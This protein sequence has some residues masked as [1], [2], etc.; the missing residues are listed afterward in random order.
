MFNEMTAE[1]VIK[2]FE[3]AYYVRMTVHDAAGVLADVTTV[4]KKYNISVSQIR[5]DKKDDIIPII[6]VTRKTSENAMNAAIAE[7]EKLNNVI[8]VDNVIRVEE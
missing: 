8:K 1:D 7:I 4:L 5:Q 2:D 6:F 3:S